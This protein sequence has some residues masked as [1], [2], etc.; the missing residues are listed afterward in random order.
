M[1]LYFYKKSDT[2]KFNIAGGK[3]K[4]TFFI[5]LLALTSLNILNFAGSYHISKTPYIK[6][7]NSNAKIS[8][9]KAREIALTHARVS[10]NNAR[11]T[12]IKMDIENGI[13]VYELEFYV[14]NRKYEY[15]I[16]ANTGEI[17]EFE[18]D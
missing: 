14:N 13:L 10:K 11:F 6:I 7:S 9:E 16:N 15:S 17:V 18:I 8:S 5:V 4:K 12:K 2:L 1:I 3:M